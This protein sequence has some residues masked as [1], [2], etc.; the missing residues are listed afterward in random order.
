MRL[1]ASPTSGT[2]ASKVTNPG[3]AAPQLLPGF[4]GAPAQ[5][6]AKCAD[7]VYQSTTGQ[8]LQFVSG[9]GTPLTDS[10]LDSLAGAGATVLTVESGFRV[11]RHGLTTAPGNNS[12]SRLVNRTCEDELANRSK[13]FA[14]AQIIGKPDTRDLPGLIQSGETTVCTRA[15]LDTV[16]AGVGAIVVSRLSQGNYSVTVPYAQVGEVDY[17]TLNLSVTA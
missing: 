10:Q 8:L 3:T 9:V 7:A 5:C 2:M 11:I 12:Y 15:V 4:F 13:A 17:L 6:G 1:A 16:I 14:L